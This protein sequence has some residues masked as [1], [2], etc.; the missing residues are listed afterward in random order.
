M[1][2]LVNNRY[3]S[4]TAAQFFTEYVDFPGINLIFLLNLYII[5]IIESKPLLDTGIA[6]IKFIATVWNGI[7]GVRISCSLLYGL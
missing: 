2:Y 1:P 6:N 7:P 4:S 5:N 3:T